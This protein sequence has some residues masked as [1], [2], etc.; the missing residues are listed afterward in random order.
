M[1]VLPE[2]RAQL[3]GF[4][5]PVGLT[6]AFVIPVFTMPNGSNQLFVQ[7]ILPDGR[8][9][10][11]ICAA[12]DDDDELLTCDG[13]SLTKAPDEPALFAF[14]GNANKSPVVAEMVSL[15]DILVD[16][17]KY[18]VLDPVLKLHIVEFCNL[19]EQRAD[20]RAQAYFAMIDA[21]GEF[22]AASWAASQL[23]VPA[24]AQ[25]FPTAVRIWSGGYGGRDSFRAFLPTN[26]PENLPTTDRERLR[27]LPRKLN[28]KHDWA[29]SS[30]I[31]IDG[32]AKLSAAGNGFVASL[33]TID[34]RVGFQSVNVLVD[35]LQFVQSRPYEVLL[36][37]AKAVRPFGATIAIA[38]P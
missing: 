35:S 34:R 26:Y 25:V 23:L 9:E 11:F 19:S 2:G 4:V 13:A 24:L 38:R 21:I 29:S 36:Q 31:A 8:I 6:P 18:G 7:E 37:L 16:F 22:A 3:V 12:V 14:V 28:R 5:N 33:P 20:A 30:I 1:K 10:Q 15:Q 32:E 27:Q 17:L